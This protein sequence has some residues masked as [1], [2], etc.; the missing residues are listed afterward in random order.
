MQEEIETRMQARLRPL[1]DRLVA[2]LY[3]MNRDGLDILYTKCKSIGAPWDEETL[4]MGV[5]FLKTYPTFDVGSFHSDMSRTRYFVRVFDV[6]NTI[7][8][9]SMVIT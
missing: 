3:G 6:I 7:S 8:A 9:L 2:A 4:L 1:S 5:N